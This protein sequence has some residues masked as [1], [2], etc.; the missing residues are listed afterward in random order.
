MAFCNVFYVVFRT[1]RPEGWTAALGM[2]SL[3]F[4]LG[5]VRD[6][7]WRSTAAAGAVSGLAFLCHPNAALYVGIFGLTAL[8]LSIRERQLRTVGSFIAGGIPVLLL[9][10]AFVI[11]ARG[12]SLGTF[13]GK[14]VYR[15][16]L[17]ENVYAPTLSETVAEFF[18]NYTLGIK[19][20][21][22]LLFEA[23]LLVAGIVLGRLRPRLRLVAVW[24]LAFFV[25]GLVALKPFATRH[26]AEV[27]VFVMVLL[28]MGLQL[29][30]DRIRDRGLGGR[31]L[32]LVFV[33][34]TGFYLLHNL[35]GEGYLWM[36]QAKQTAYSDVER[37]LDDRVPD[38]ATVL[39]LYHFYFPL[40]HN[41]LYTGYTRWEYFDRYESQDALIASGDLDYIVIS[42]FRARDLNT[43]SGRK[44][45]GWG[46]ERQRRIYE[47]IH[48]AAVAGGTLVDSLPTVGYGTIEI[49]AMKTEGK[50]P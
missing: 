6:R 18:R 40:R 50:T 13:F 43:T 24:G 39:S 12:E 30:F 8:V 28:G 4:A 32:A 17:S 48:D 5:M 26:F 23:G 27:L 42:D 36:R 41:R 14:M 44:I 31:R 15:T 46:Q 10:V 37:W 16:Q 7:S 11:W 38:E 9:L 29:A 49:Y 21:A 3:Y 25:L 22:I 20:L 47:K 33:A 19:R 1:V 45:E 2:W 34:L 35:G